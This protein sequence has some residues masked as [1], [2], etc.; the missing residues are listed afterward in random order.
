MEGDTKVSI[1]ILSPP[2]ADEESHFKITFKILQSGNP[3]KILAQTVSLKTD[4]TP[5]PSI[6]CIIVI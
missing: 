6:F 2:F 4:L 1:V 5:V 3:K